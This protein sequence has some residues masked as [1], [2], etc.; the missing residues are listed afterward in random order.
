MAVT[1][2]ELSMPFEDSSRSGHCE[3]IKV[4]LRGSRKAQ[5]YPERLNSRG[6]IMN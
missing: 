2:C 3:R 1:G 4:H 5:D 6:E